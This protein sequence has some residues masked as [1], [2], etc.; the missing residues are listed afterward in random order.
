MTA[1]RKLV[2]TCAVM[3][4]SFVA[5]QAMANI[6]QNGG[7]EAG[8][9]SWT[10]SGMFLQS[11]AQYAHTGTKTV[12]TGCVG[13]ACVST[14]N[15]GA[16]LRQDLATEAGVSYDLSFF[17]GENS[18]ATSEMSVFW[19]G[20]QIADILNPA[21]RTLPAVPFGGMVQY[22]FANLLANN[23]TTSL[24]IHG[25][26]DP[27]AIYFDDVSVNASAVPEPASLALVGLGLLGLA[28]ARRKVIKK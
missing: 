8:A 19:N 26:Q 16:F 18:G 27:G 15:S 7:F 24:E 11:N 17:V 12:A 9:T 28:T 25:R 2:A 6:V 10:L 13:H 4:A 23:T 5:P 1:I 3:C 14:L 21:N 20:V 22:T